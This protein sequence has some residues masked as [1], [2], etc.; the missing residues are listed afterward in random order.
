M[1]NIAVS[2]SPS[3]SAITGFFETHPVTT[4]DS[5]TIV[6]YPVAL[7]LDSTQSAIVM[8]VAITIRSKYIIVRAQTVSAASN[9][10]F[11][12]RAVRLSDPS[13]VTTANTWCCAR[14]MSAAVIW[15]REQLTVCSFVAIVTLARLHSALNS[16]TAGS[17]E[18]AEARGTLA[19]MLW[20]LAVRSV[21][22]WVAAAQFSTTNTV[23]TANSRT[24]VVDSVALLLNRAQNTII[25]VMAI[26]IC[27]KQ[28]VIRAIT[29]S[30]AG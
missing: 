15:A 13:S 18:V 27:S 30:A 20:V 6:V 4:A 23:G 10:T 12:N 14:S 19:H 24:V 7:V 26:A 17:V 3:T 5:Q 2:S 25:M 8:I 29:V 9:V 1:R 21:P 11:L 22:S 16:L 28:S